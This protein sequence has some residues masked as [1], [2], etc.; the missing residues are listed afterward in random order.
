MGATDVDVS[1]L[2]CP[3]C[4]PRLVEEMGATHLIPEIIP[5]LARIMHR[6]LSRSDESADLSALRHALGH[7]LA[8]RGYPLAGRAVRTDDFVGA[9][10]NL[11]IIRARRGRRSTTSRNE[12]LSRWQLGARLL[13]RPNEHA[14]F[15]PN[16]ERVT[17]KYT[18][19]SVV[20]YTLQ[21]LTPSSPA[22]N[23]TESR[24]TA[25]DRLLK[26]V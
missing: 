11:C 8:G 6:F 19:V 25:S 13:E 15:S 14:V 2:V 22:V 26:L 7:P 18:W 3:K 12:F 21:D 10:E 24:R 20:N 23:L 1:R 16:F 4:K 17:K 9:V 5:D